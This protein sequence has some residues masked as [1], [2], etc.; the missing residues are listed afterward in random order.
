[1]LRILLFSCLLDSAVGYD[2]NL[3]ETTQRITSILA[4]RAGS[5]TG[6]DDALEMDMQRIEAKLAELSD[7]RLLNDHAGAHR[8]RTQ[9]LMAAADHDVRSAQ[10]VGRDPR[11]DV[12][13]E[14]AHSH[15][16]LAAAAKEDNGLPSCAVTLSED[17]DST[18]KTLS[19]GTAFAFAGMQTGI[20]FGVALDLFACI[21]SNIGLLMEKR[22][23]TNEQDRLGSADEVTSYKLPLWWAGFITFCCAQLAT[24]VAMSFISVVITAPLGS[25]T[26]V[27]NLFTSAF[28]LKE[29]ANVVQVVSSLVI[30]LGCVLTTVF[31]PWAKAENSLECFRVYLASHSFHIVGSLVLATLIVVLLASRALVLP[32]QK[33]TTNQ[34]EWPTH[35]RLGR[36]LYP[37][38]SGM[39]AVWSMNCGAALM[40]LLGT[41]FAGHA[42]T[43][44]GAY[45]SWTCLA[46][47]IF[48][49]VSW[50]KQM[51][52]CNLVLNATYVVPINFAVLTVL[53]LPFSSS[54]HGT[55]A[56]WHPETLPLASYI[57]GMVLCVA[58]MVGLVGS[59]GS[60][61][62]ESDNTKTSTK[63]AALE[64]KGS[65]DTGQGC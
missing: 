51:N 35:A 1:M 63:Q 58:G 22:A 56:N 54:L 57:V 29:R 39:T 64:Q 7:G 9:A 61:T 48:S 6:W 43:V 65:S 8:I 46:V 36:W 28:Y 60:M 18:Q 49:I 21:F 14:V 41:A 47:Y 55:L 52:D 31:A 44:F 30:V 32:S 45:E 25:F 34:D 33:I 10:R 38:A 20:A 17:K 4:E 11:A 59:E 53:T 5:E 62:T 40:R 19:S 3:I 15:K 37:V 24:G 23:L 2:E 50:Q 27:V 26:L 13:R 42:A 12:D 16:I